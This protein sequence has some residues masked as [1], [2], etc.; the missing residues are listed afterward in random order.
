MND[1]PQA[2][3]KVLLTGASG[4]IG[5]HAAV[6]LAKAGVE[7]HLTSR[8]RPPVDVGVWHQADLLEPEAIKAV[9]STVRPHVVLHAAWCVEHSRFWTDPNNLNWV[10]ATVCLVR[11][12]VEGGAS[13]FVGLG[14][15]YEYDWPENGICDEFGTPVAGHTLYDTSK[16]ATRR[17]L[18]AYCR[19]VGIGFAWARLFF[20]YGPGEAPMRLVAS[21]ARALARGEEAALS[22]GTTV[23]DFMDVRDAG[24]ALAKLGLSQV[25]GAI[26]IASGEGVRISDLVLKMGDLA[27]CLDL[28]NIGAL[29]DRP[30]DPPRI[31][32]DTR[33]LREELGFRPSISLEQGL[34]G[35]LSYWRARLI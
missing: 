14:T 24:A 7:L 15:C 30:G 32:A 11:A 9:V 34:G 12:A 31:V 6:A 13:R 20:L 1:A 28:I 22:S 33:R 25:K 8:S 35:A 29:P 5:R 17:V 10:A 2:E 4:F 23:R 3:R 27:G 16:D 26:N 21:V 18:D 19:E